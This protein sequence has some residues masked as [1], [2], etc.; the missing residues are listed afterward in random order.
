MNID[1]NIREAIDNLK[2]Q[3]QCIAMVDEMARRVSV[4]RSAARR[5][6]AQ[7]LVMSKREKR[8]IDMVWVAQAIYAIRK[9]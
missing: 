8:Q 6:L 7:E 2:F 5:L 1:N 4:D 3:K 9:V